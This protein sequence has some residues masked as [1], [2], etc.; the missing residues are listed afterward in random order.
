MLATISFHSCYFS[1]YRYS[2]AHPY[3]NKSNVNGIY[4]VYNVSIKSSFNY[5]LSHL[6]TMIDKEKNPLIPHMCVCVC[7]CVIGYYIIVM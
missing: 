1:V 7:V 4:K 6:K 2:L 5:I 3:V